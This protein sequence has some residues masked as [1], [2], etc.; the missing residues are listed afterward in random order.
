MYI[1][2]QSQQNYQVI[3]HTYHS[4]CY[5]YDKGQR[6]SETIIND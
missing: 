3:S 2:V 5:F 4:D 1:F 6:G